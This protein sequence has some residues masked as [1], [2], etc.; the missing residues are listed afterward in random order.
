MLPDDWVCHLHPP[1][2]PSNR[3]LTSVTNSFHNKDNQNVPPVK[4]W[5]DAKNPLRRQALP[6][7][8]NSSAPA[9]DGLPE[10]EFVGTAM[11]SD[12]WVKVAGAFWIEACNL[13]QWRDG[14]CRLTPR[15][16][17][18][19]TWHVNEFLQGRIPKLPKQS[20]KAEGYQI[21]LPQA[22]LARMI[23]PFYNADPSDCPTLDSEKGSSKKRSRSTSPAL[24]KNTRQKIDGPASLT[25]PPTTPFQ[26]SP[27]PIFVKPARRDHAVQIKRP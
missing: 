7:K 24:G 3:I 11:N 12:S 10:L 4:K 17:G 8:H 15:S 23:A 13:E 21:K 16:L 19:L 26:V 14:G 2:V 20:K 25:L 22:A 27:S 5:P 6:C 9:H 18:T 1:P